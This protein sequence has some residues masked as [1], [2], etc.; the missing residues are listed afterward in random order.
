MGSR[1]APEGALQEVVHRH[2]GCAC[3]KKGVMGD[4]ESWGS[5]VPW[6][7]CHRGWGGMGSVYDPGRAL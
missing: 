7:G 1:C 6:E 2:R 3:P 5:C 4:E